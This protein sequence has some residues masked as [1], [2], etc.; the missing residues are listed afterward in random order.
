MALLAVS[1]G[2]DTKQLKDLED[3]FTSSGANN[4]GLVDMDEFTKAMQK[5][6][7]TDVAE[8]KEYFAA[9]NQDGPFPAFPSFFPVLPFLSSRYRRL[10][11]LS[12]PLPC[13]PKRARRR[14]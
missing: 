4:D 8:I 11:F 14:R 10:S 7:M 9:I 1:F 12:Q 5:H 6:G 3:A 2:A 13:Y